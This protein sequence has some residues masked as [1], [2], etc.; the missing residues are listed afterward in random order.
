VVDEHRVCGFSQGSPVSCHFLN[1]TSSSH[2]HPSS[3]RQSCL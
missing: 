2:H 3:Q 1:S